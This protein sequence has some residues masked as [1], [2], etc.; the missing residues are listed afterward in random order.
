MRTLNRTKTQL[1]P[2]SSPFIFLNKDF[3]GLLDRDFDDKNEHKYAYGLLDSVDRIQHEHVPYDLE[4]DA[5][6]FYSRQITENL[7]DE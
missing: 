7:S 1:K 5:Q 6:E 3:T 2:K 4:N